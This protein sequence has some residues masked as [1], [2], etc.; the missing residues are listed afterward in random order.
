MFYFLSNKGNLIWT[1]EANSPVTT[2]A[3]TP[4]G[5]YIVV[6]SNNKNVYLLSK[7]QKT[8]WSLETLGEINS[9][10]I[11]F[12]GNYICAGTKNGWIYIISKSGEILSK[13]KRNDG[14]INIKINPDGNYIVAGSREGGVYIISN[15]GQELWKSLE[16]KGIYSV[17]INPDG[18]KIAVGSMDTIY[19]ISNKGK[20]IW[21]YQTYNDKNY[22]YS[23]NSLAIS[24]D[25]TTLV[26]TSRDSVFLFNHGE[27]KQF[28]LDMYMPTREND[29]IELGTNPKISETK[30]NSYKK[31]E[32]ILNILL[33]LLGIMGKSEY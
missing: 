28:D 6:G 13:S 4:D 5:E 14:V 25:S 3:I 18:S 19:V 7:N 12:D 33:R 27:K 21:S 9:V 11:S 23:I 16:D 20:D 30:E 26:S 17:S 24:L 8:I 31:P 32:G 2:V 22:L 10:D 29:I 15:N 1:H